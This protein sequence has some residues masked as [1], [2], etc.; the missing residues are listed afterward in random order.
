MPVY[1]CQVCAV[2]TEQGDTFAYRQKPYCETHAPDGAVRMRRAGAISNESPHEPSPTRIAL[3]GISV[4][5]GD[6]LYL[7]WQLFLSSLIIGA[8]AGIVWVILQAACSDWL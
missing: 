7:T 8:G 5:F 1:Q 2:E 3:T 4:P 6:V